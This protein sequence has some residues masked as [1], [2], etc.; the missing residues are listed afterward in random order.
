MLSE[1]SEPSS[2]AGW[3][4]SEDLWPGAGDQQP[5]NQLQE[6]D[7]ILISSS[8]E[9]DSDRII[10]SLDSVLSDKTSDLESGFEYAPALS[11]RLEYFRK[12]VKGGVWQKFGN[13]WHSS[14]T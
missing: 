1:G 8:L 2:Q 14:Y 6:T 10:E 11:M 7:P 9:L 3:E 13:T 12:P 5:W 4:G